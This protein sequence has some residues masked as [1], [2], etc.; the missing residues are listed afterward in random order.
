M[1]LLLQVIS[2]FLSQGDE[3]EEDPLAVSAP[4]ANAYEFQSGGVVEMLEKLKDKF[5]DLRSELEKE[6]MDAKHA[7]QMLMQ[8]LQANH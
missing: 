8:Q 5:E 7:Y 6:E 2:A 1:T 3:M 4:Q